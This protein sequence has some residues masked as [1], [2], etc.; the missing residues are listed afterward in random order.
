[1]T[2]IK[3]HKI[4]DF[5]T[6]NAENIF[7]KSCKLW[8][9]NSNISTSSSVH[10]LIYIWK[11]LNSAWFSLTNICHQKLRSFFVELFFIFAAYFTVTNHKCTVFCS[12]YDCCFHSKPYQNLIKVKKVVLSILLVGNILQFAAQSKESEIDKV[13]IRGKFVTLPVKKVNEN[14]TVIRRKQIINWPAKSV[15]EVLAQFHW[16]WYPPKRR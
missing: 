9:K 16:F 6:E 4:T 3:A 2:K 8:N 13:N 11:I 15:E 14:V 10:L 12:F 5:F 7:L 1:M